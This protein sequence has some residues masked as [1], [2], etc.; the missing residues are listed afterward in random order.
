M[1]YYYLGPVPTT[2]I[3]MNDYLHCWS[4]GSSNTHF[5]DNTDGIYM[6]FYPISGTWKMTYNISQ[7]CTDST[8]CKE[9]L[10]PVNGKFAFTIQDPQSNQK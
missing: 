8:V 7:Q 1:K 3:V 9:L 5:L 4:V 10:I 6:P 2:M